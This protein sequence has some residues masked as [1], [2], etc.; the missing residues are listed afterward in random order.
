MLFSTLFVT[1]AILMN[2]CVNLRNIL[3]LNQ[4][5][6]LAATQRLQLLLQRSST[7]PEMLQRGR[8]D[9]TTQADHSTGGIL[10]QDQSPLQKVQN[11]PALQTIADPGKYVLCYF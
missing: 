6:D 8:V 5:P 1:V 11:D 4:V 3:F 10:Q 9:L 2:F 7:E